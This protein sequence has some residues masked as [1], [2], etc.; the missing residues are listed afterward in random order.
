M[1][2]P[3]GWERPD[4]G[5]FDVTEEFVILHGALELS[6]RTWTPGDYGLVPAG[7]RREHT[8]TPGGAV[9]LAY[10][11]GS[12]RWQAAA[13]VLPGEVIRHLHLDEPDVSRTRVLRRDRAGESLWGAGPPPDASVGAIEQLDVRSASWSV[14][15]LGSSTGAT[16]SGPTFRRVHSGASA[17][18]GSALG[19]L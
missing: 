6:G 13:G 11:T 9:A 7:A 12:P 18:L 10:F 15:L 5:S 8:A 16:L 4:A 3:A 2:F 14:S 19:E 1:R 17:R